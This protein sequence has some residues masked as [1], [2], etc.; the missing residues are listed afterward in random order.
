MIFRPL[1][2][3]MS[4]RQQLG[5]TIGSFH[6]SDGSYYTLLGCIYDNSQNYLYLSL[7]FFG[8]IIDFN[9]G[10]DED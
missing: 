9:G 2:F 6:F 4:T 10:D 7:A 8:Y 3:A 1:E 5:I